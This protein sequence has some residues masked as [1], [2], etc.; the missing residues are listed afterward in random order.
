MSTAS[1]GAQRQGVPW[2]TSALRMPNNLCMQATTATLG[3]LLATGAL[4]IE[5]RAPG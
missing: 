2:R 4:L 5:W 1:P 3:F